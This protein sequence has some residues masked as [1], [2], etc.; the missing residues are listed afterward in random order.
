MALATSGIDVGKYSPKKGERTDFYLNQRVIQPYRRTR[1]TRATARRDDADTQNER[2][3]CDS[4]LET[5]SSSLTQ[6]TFPIGNGFS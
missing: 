6:F 3:F 2:G 1:K 5:P 4:H